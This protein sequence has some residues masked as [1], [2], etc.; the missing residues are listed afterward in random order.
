[1]TPPFQHNDLCP[2]FH[3]KT[4][5][6]QEH[7]VNSCMIQDICNFVN[8]SCCCIMDEPYCG[9]IPFATEANIMSA[10]LE[11]SCSIIQQDTAHTHL[12]GV[13]CV[14][15]G[16]R[17]ICSMH[18]DESST[19]MWHIHSSHRRTSD[20]QVFLL[21]PPISTEWAATLYHQFNFKVS[22]TPSICSFL[23]I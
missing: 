2:I 21:S 9:D 13:C 6:Q 19:S 14:F 3:R 16:D 4:S 1:M 12:R 10:L 11:K 17:L 23:L 5:K 22:Q 20:W 7:N 8:I 15:E 18:A